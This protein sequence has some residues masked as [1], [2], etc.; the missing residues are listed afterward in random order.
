[1]KEQMPD[2]LASRAWTAFTLFPELWKHGR[3]GAAKP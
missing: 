1:M 3:V 2:S